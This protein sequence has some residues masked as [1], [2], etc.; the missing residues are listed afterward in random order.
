MSL[1]WIYLL[2]MVGTAIVVAVI[3]SAAQDANLAT[4]S[5][6]RKAMGRLG[7]LLGVLVGLA[8]LVFILS[9]I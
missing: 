9:R 5:V 7:R 8:A 1:G 3:Y 2:S 6:A 4:P